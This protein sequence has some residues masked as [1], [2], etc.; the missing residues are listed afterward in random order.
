MKIYVDADA[1]PNPAKEI[2]FRAAIRHQLEM[3]MV[4]NQILQLPLHSNIK[5]LQ[6]N[7]GFDEADNEIVRLINDGDLL[8]SADIPLASSAIDKGATVINPR[9][10]IYTRENIK[11]ELATRDLMAH[12]RD[13][14]EIRGG[15]AP[16][17]DKDKASFA[18]ALDK[19]LNKA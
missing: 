18:N 10:R 16:Y 3:L 11:Q 12:L 8:V 14:L 4:A 1:C 15:P 17:N 9:G 2:L 7:K 13:N 19:I 6:V 5:M